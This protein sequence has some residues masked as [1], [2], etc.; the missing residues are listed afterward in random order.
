ME[1]K[2]LF[3]EIPGGKNKFHSAIL[4]SFSFNFHHFEYQ[5]L[6]SLKHKYITNIGVLV[7]SRMLDQSA[8]LTSSGLRQLTQSYSVN[9]V[10]CKGAFHPKINFIVGDDEILIVFG[11]GNISPGGHGKNHET[12]TTFYADSKESPLLPLI[13]EIWDYIQF[14]SQNLEGFSKDR[15]F[16]SVPKN[17]SLLN[18]PVKQKHRFHKIDDDLEIALVYNEETSIIAQVSKLIPTEIIESISILSPYY[19]EDGAFLLQLL[20]K[21]PN[22]KIEVYLPK[23][24]GLPPTKMVSNKRISFFIWE[25]TK[26]GQMN[27][28]G[29]DAYERKL[30]SK[31][32]NFKSKEFNYFLI[33]SANATIPA[34]GSSDKRGINEEFGAI[35]KSKKKD[36]FTELNI[37]KSTKVSSLTDYVRSTTIALETVLKTF[38]P[39]IQLLGC[40]L[41]G[42]KVK[43]YMKGL[44]STLGVKMT[45]YNDGGLEVFK[46]EI[47]K[48]QDNEFECGIT[49]DEITE[50]PIY[51]QL[52]NIEGELI[53]NKQLINYTEKLYHTDPSKENRTIR[54][55]IGAL[56]IGR[57]NEFEILNYINDLHSN[58]SRKSTK[59]NG[60]S[61]QQDAMKETTAH[62]EMTYAEAMSASKDRDLGDKLSQ[63]H[64]SIRIWEVI[65][66]LFKE[67]E[68]R[69]TNEMNDEEE[70]A[71]ASIS[72]DRTSIIS[73]SYI[74]ELKDDSQCNS[75][76]NKSERLS[77]DYIKSLNI[78]DRD[79]DSMINEVGFCQLLIVTHVLTAI[80]HF[81]DYDVEFSIKKKRESGFD[82]ESWRK[83]LI[84]NYS[85]QVRD[86]LNVFGKF[87]IKHNVEDLIGND[88]REFKMKNYQQKV[89]SHVL[90]YHYLINQNKEDNPHAQSLNLVCLNLFDKLG[91][92]DENSDQYIEQISKTGNNQLFNFS[93][94]LKLKKQLINTYKNLSES[95]SFF[96]EKHRGIC[97]IL[98]KTDSSVFYKSLFEPQIKNEISCKEF[99]NWRK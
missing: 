6:K 56:E 4:T 58:D 1:E 29:S 36:F 24:H 23:F 19:D 22:T 16:K 73:E 99:N 55:L 70:D 80:H 26:R 69:K 15:I 7:D 78:I 76:L 79:K 86:I 37:T 44:T 52:Q 17:C 84:Y 46:K 12:F 88:L 18:E 31:V 83:T 90:I 72:N 54:G 51:I 33:G 63:T 21:F 87:I 25:E 10:Y 96:R 91:L 28:K 89:L 60:F 94:V 93:N 34:F 77:N 32:F 27:F 62:P 59:T 67:K 41:L 43:L 11:S 50:N 45:F 5:V 85:T 81:L 39:K 48:N 47:F 74:R 38:S 97:F 95:S 14:L 9:G 68:L 35:Y 61:V 98:S 57:I 3:L 64:N 71:S 53:S 2:K 30:H 65:S 40:D 49:R 42:T 92:P 8:G 82:S 20:E 66:Q 75:L 13:H